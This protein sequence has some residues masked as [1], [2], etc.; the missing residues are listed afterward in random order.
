LPQNGRLHAQTT[1][2]SQL[3]KAKAPSH[4]CMHGRRCRSDRATGRSNFKV[5][6]SRA[7]RGVDTG[8]PAGRHDPPLGFRS[9][10][11]RRLCLVGRQLLLFLGQHACTQK[12]A[13]SS[14][15]RCSV[16]NQCAQETY[17]KS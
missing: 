3:T 1:K 8:V 11:G 6:S 17:R 4:S 5:L 12:P 10:D 13:I 2:A 14:E 15:R 16:E 7:L 9:T